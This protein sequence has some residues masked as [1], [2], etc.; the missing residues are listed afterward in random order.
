MCI[1]CVDLFF[2]VSNYECV[3]LVLYVCFGFRMLRIF[4]LFCF[5]SHVFSPFIVEFCLAAENICVVI[6]SVS[7]LFIYL[8]TEVFVVIVLTGIASCTRIFSRS[9]DSHSL[10]ARLYLNSCVYFVNVTAFLLG[11]VLYFQY[12]YM[13]RC[14]CSF[15]LGPIIPV[16]GRKIGNYTKQYSATKRK[17]FFVVIGNG[18]TQAICYHSIFLPWN[19]WTVITKQK[20]QKKQTKSSPAPLPL[21][22][23]R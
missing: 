15:V 13:L 6:Y 23:V 7:Y 9:L 18:N 20:Q 17:R 1:C 12:T 14:F 4:V 16:I 21:L 19:Y 10:R 8:S 2:C 22:P 11:I 3:A 5:I